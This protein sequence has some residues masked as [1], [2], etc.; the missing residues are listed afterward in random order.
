M[1]DACPYRR[2]TVERCG[3]DHAFAFIGST[4]T[5]NRL[6]MMEAVT[7]ETMPRC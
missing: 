7:L 6:L 1:T 3:L 4:Q 2:E 5:R